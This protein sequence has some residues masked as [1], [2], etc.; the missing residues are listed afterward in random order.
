M[1]VHIA[2][3]SRHHHTSAAGY[4]C[5]LGFVSNTKSYQAFKTKAK[6]LDCKARDKVV[7]L[8]PRSRLEFGERAFSVAAPRAWNSIPADLRA[9]LNTPTFKKNL[10]TFFIPC[11]LFVILT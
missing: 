2:T 4:F 10:K 9:T 1:P 3:A 8:V 6:D 5:H 11:I 7:R